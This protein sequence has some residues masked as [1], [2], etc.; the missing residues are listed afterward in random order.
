MISTSLLEKNR[1]LFEV[2]DSEEDFAYVFKE[3]L[4]VD[5]MRGNMYMGVVYDWEDYQK[6]R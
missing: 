6:Y 3:F 4:K 1:Y 2:G 5:D